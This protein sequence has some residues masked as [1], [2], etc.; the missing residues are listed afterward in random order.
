VNNLKFLFPNNSPQ[1]PKSL[2]I[3]GDKITLF[4]RSTSHQW[5]CRFKLDSGAWHTAS[6]HTDQTAEAMTRAI[7]IYE[8]V[9]YR[10]ANDLA[11]KTKTFRAVAV[12]ELQ[13]LRGIHKELRSKQTTNDYI[14]NLERYLIPFFGPYP[15]RDINQQLVDDF[16]SWRIAQMGRV[17]KHST[18]RHHASA[19]NRVIKRA[20]S[21]GL[22]NTY[23]E[24]ISLNVEG[25]RGETRP[26]FSREEIE[27]LLKFMPE[28]ETQVRQ[29][30]TERFHAMARLCRCYVE[31]LLYTGI[32]TGTESM[33]IRWKS[34][35]WHWIDQK[36]YLRVWVSGKTG[37]RYLIARNELIPSLERLV[38]WQGVGQNL[39]DVV[40]R[41]IDRKIFVFPA[42]D[43]PYDLTGVFS[44]LMTESGLLE[45][46]TG[47][48]RTLYSLR[49]TYATF[50][51]TDGID[52]HTLARQMGTSV[53]MIERHYSKL[54]P[55]MSAEKLA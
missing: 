8:Q 3:L 37:P 13:A 5:Q 23:Q 12:E 21:S 4:K 45:D 24:P 18:Q 47:R 39:D 10:I 46:H 17:A 34:L 11:I 40:A 14:F 49:H 41:K 19:F 2:T 15:V 50:A 9:R 28:W 25:D 36:R 16:D 7:E 22:L 33:P 55:M 26:A 35:H 32:R 51:L 52:I 6:T 54:T 30:R 53:S 29:D 31:F 20:R 27:F 44:R 42:G 38:A 43:Q 1:T 48:K